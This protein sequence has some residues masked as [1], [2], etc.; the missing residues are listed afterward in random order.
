M[1]DILKLLGEQAVRRSRIEFEQIHGLSQTTADFIADTV[2][3]EMRKGMAKFTPK[4]N[5]EG[6]LR[7]VI[8][9]QDK[10][11]VEITRRITDKRDVPFLVGLQVKADSDRKRESQQQS[12][13]CNN[14]L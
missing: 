9:N 10:Q 8:T 13:P 11:R 4:K 5:G 1:I 3:V 6:D 12:K 7:A 2:G 14:Q